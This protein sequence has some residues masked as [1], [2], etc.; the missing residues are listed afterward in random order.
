MKER[1]DTCMSMTKITEENSE[2]LMPRES[3]VMLPG[4]S[5]ISRG[6]TV[7]GDRGGQERQ[8]REESGTD[9]Y[10]CLVIRDVGSR[11]KVCFAGTSLKRNCWMD[12]FPLLHEARL[13]RGG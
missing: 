8:R 11:K 3:R 1:D 5:H 9:S 4:Q 13:R 7:L 2:R 12:V 6:M 10:R